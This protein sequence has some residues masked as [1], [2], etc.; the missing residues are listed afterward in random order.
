MSSSPVFDGAV[1]QPLSP[2]MLLNFPVHPVTL[3][4]AKSNVVQTLNEGRSLQI[5]TLNPEMLMRAQQDPDLAAILRTAG[6]ILP[7][8]AGVVWALRRQGLSIKRLPGIEFAESLLAWAAETGEGVALLGASQES[9]DQTVTGLSA[10]YPGLRIIYTHHGFFPA[11]GEEEMRIVHACA[12]EK[13][14][15]VLVA[16]GVP[17]Q[18]QWIS[19]YMPYFHGAAMMGVGGSFDVWGGKSRRAPALMRRLNL[20]W[21]YRISTEPWRLKRTY[22]TLP[23][24]VVKVLLA[25]KKA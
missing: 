24:F 25:E 21:V 2:A 11:G 19:R 4:Q 16:L 10:R 13:P 17:R 6:L 15:L 8:G 3:E 5:I 9:L 20:E 14:R 22:K 7:D 18:E 23:L 1:E 12:A